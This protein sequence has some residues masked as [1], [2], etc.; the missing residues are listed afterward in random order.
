LEGLEPVASHGDEL[1]LLFKMKDAPLSKEDEGFASSLI[2]YWTKFATEGN[3][4]W[5]PVS[6]KMAPQYA[7]LNDEGG[8][9]VKREMYFT[10][11]MFFISSTN[12]IIKSYR[13]FDLESHPAILSV[14]EREVEVD[15]EE[16]EENLL[17]EKNYSP[18]K[19]FFFAIAM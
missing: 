13:N 17:F 10:E 4:G 7:I 11:K 15:E 8:I 19:M 12:D 18:I 6:N 9:S 16:T 2:K 14:M 3:P 1:F 5:R